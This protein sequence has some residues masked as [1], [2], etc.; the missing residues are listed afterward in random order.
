MTPRPAM[1]YANDP[2]YTTQMTDPEIQTVCSNSPLEQEADQTKLVTEFDIVKF[3]HRVFFNIFIDCI[4]K[5]NRSEIRRRNEFACILLI[6]TSKLFRVA[7]ILLLILIHSQLTT[8]FCLFV[9]IL[10][11]I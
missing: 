11:C 10:D 1:R 5:C 8:F 2:E 9:E 7:H 4:Q 6:F 3:S